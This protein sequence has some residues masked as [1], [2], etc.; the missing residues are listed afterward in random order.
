MMVLQAITIADHR[1]KAA[2]KSV[3]FIQRYIFPGGFIPSVTAMLSSITKSS[4]MRI[5]HLEDIGAHYAR[6][7]QCWRES[8]MKKLRQVR[9]LGYNDSFLRMWEY[10]YCYCEGAFM[11]RA[12]GNV[13]ILLVRPDNR[14]ES[15]VPSLTG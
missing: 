12:I 5:F 1:Y 3:D 6:T 9:S 11:E 15:L 2:L 14:R 4:D 13:Q 10:Y 8:F 7:L